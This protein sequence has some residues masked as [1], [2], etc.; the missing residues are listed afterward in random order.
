MNEG[1]FESSGSNSFDSD[2]DLQQT[3][4]R[5]LKKGEE[6]ENLVSTKKLNP[7][8]SDQDEDESVKIKQ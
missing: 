6:K 4:R 1:S 8:E 3:K 5:R 7:D 2:K